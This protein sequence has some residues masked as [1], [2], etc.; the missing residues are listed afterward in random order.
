MRVTIIKLDG[1]VSID[2]EGYSGID[3]SYLPD[4][5][6]ALQWYGDVGEVEKVI[7]HPFKKLMGESESVTSLDSYQKCLD[8]WAV[9]KEVVRQQEE[10][11][12]AARAEQEKLMAQEA[13]SV[14][15]TAPSTT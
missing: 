1:F 5:F 6:H 2:G 14:I 7:P 8:G 10:A 3:L 15:L 11:R 12:A 13:N 4:D 9:A